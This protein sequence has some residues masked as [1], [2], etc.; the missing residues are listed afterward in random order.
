MYSR[1][2]YMRI[3]RGSPLIL[4][5]SASPK[6]GRQPERMGLEETLQRSMAQETVSAATVFL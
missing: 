1:S 6:L 2:S 4:E 3:S 5:L